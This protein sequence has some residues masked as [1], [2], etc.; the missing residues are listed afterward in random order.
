MAVSLEM[1]R[2][3]C[4]VLV[5]V[6]MAVGAL[7]YFSM[8]HEP[9]FVQI[10]A[11]AAA[12]AV[13]LFGLRSRPALFSALAAML[14]CILGALSAKVETWRAGTRML[15][16][17]V[18]TQLTGRVVEIERMATGRVRL[19]IDV[20][21][22]ARPLLRYAPDR[23]RVSARAIAGGVTVGEV[24]TGLVRLMPPSGPVRPG[25]YDFSFES[26]F[27]GI[28]ASGFFLRGPE[29]VSSTAAL[30]WTTEFRG[31]VERVRYSMAAHISGQIG[32]AEG[33][34]AAALVVGVRAGIPEDVNE[35]LRRAG[36]YHIIS[37][38]GL[39]MAL[40]AGTIMALLRAGFALFPDF[41]SRHAVKKYAAAIALVGLSGYLFVSGA[42][43]A[44]QRSF[45]MFAVML[46]AVLF[47][48]AALT[49]RNLAIAA[50]I[51]LAVSPHEVV[52]P[53]FQMSFAA[54]A[55]LIGAYAAWSD[56]RASR[57][58][59]SPVS[60]SWPRRVLY[61]LVTASVGLAVTSVVAGAAT[62]IYASWHFQQMPSLGLLTNLTAMPIVSII[63]MPFA[64]LGT[65]AMPLGLD[66]P[67]FYVMGQ[68]LFATV[69][70]SRWFAERSPIDAVGLV[71]PVSVIIL[72]T[73]LIVATITSTRLRVAAIPLALI[74]LLFLL[75]RPKPDLFVSEDGRLVG[76]DL[77][78]GRI[79]A[80]R[81]RPNEFTIE[82]WK[83]AIRA[84]EIL[85]PVGVEGTSVGHARSDAAPAGPAPV[86]GF[87]CAGGLCSA[88]HPVGV[89]VVHALD[90]QAAL[91]AC[92]SAHIVIIEDAS[93]KDVCRWKDVLVISG[94]DLA[95]HGSAEVTI[96]DRAFYLRYAITR[97][98]R[99][100]HEHRRFSR[101]ARG[102]PPYRAPPDSSKQEA[103]QRHPQAV[104]PAEPPVPMP[105]PQ[106]VL[107]AQ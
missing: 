39:H 85:R 6:F 10:A 65:L 40:V 105:Q 99:P 86:A 81:A 72:T 9:G 103:D 20:T 91:D 22:T 36:I 43:V 29:P 49:M 24:V 75:D 101:S 77:G 42:E 94:R 98:Y 1:D 50:I 92:A 100:W 12:L 66:G 61:M 88:G 107:T 34:I 8:S 5:P 48:R 102:L 14:F 18:T 55:A 58:S 45:I 38:S 28:G 30:P 93:A 51:V 46:V 37:I 44:A 19:T 21:G 82:N 87:I 32:G 106:H 23:V 56:R 63:V 80:N 68:G 90:A 47:D 13:C 53:S 59:S 41:S 78:G 76:L 79:A 7:S 70:I 62:A 84:E 89:V 97:P 69:A 16:G 73:A 33:E 15:G 4:F 67:F 104:V 95:L 25:S 74:G 3:I 11:V 71:A 83:R 57:P 96:S 35:A 52:G 64:V 60:R 27:D 26:Y 31:A 17:E 54:T 2:G